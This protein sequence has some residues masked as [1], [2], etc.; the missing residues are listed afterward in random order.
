[1]QVHSIHFRKGR[2]EDCYRIAELDDMASGGAID[3]LFHDLI[4]GLTPVQIVAQNFE[5]DEYPFTYKSAIVAQHRNEVVGFALSFPAEFHTITDEMRRFFP[6]ER[7]LHFKDFFS[8]RMEGSYYLDGL[9]VI[10]EH[11]GHGIGR[12][13]IDR[14]KEKS[15]KEGYTNLSLIVFADNLD[16]IRLYERNGF[17][18]VRPIEL[19]PHDR[20]PHHGGCLLMNCELEGLVC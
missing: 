19:N 10:P 16:A 4:P 18:I 12:G 13:L 3:Y 15:L 11:Q 8:T 9:A 7:L 17:Q 20:I 2:V 1:M 5:R 14:T 6:P